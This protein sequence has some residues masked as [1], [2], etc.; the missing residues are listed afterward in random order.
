MG[1]Y[2]DDG[3]NVKYRHVHW[4]PSSSNVAIGSTGG[5]NSGKGML[6]YNYGQKATATGGGGY[7]FDPFSTMIAGGMA[8]YGQREANRTNRDIANQNRAWQEGMSNTAHQRQ[9]RDL[10]RAGLNPILS[11]NAGASTPSGSVAH[12][13]NAL[14]AGVSTAIDTMRLQKE[15]RAVDSQTALNAASATAQQAAANYSNT[16]ARESAVRTEIAEK[17]APGTINQSR[18]A[19]KQADW[20]MKQL[21]FDN[22]NKRIQQGLGT[23]NQAK[24]LLN[25]LKG[26]KLPK[27][28]EAEGAKSRGFSEKYG[29][30]NK[31]QSLRERYNAPRPEGE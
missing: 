13:E 18:L 22:I 3:K 4:A 9:V 28:T 29:P 12:M 11:A 15:M 10:K 2:S 1:G 30:Y 23:F 14:G 8:Y 27:K 31:N 25:P 6:P 20:D 5:G 16:S 26:I 21:Q 17:T 19:E 24:D 7:S